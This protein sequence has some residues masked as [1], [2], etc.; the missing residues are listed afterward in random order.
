MAYVEIK[1]QNEKKYYYLTKNVR[2]GPN[3]W[4]K[5]RLF[6]GNKEPTQRD[7]S[8]CLKE[9]ESRSIA[10]YNSH[11]YLAQKD[12]EL[13]EDLRKSYSQ[14]MARMPK[15]AQRKMAEDT[16]IRYTYN[17]N[18][19]EGNRLTL[20]QTAMILKDRIM[21]HGVSSR[22]YNEAIN[23]KECLNYFRTYRGEL[24]QT[25]L[26]TVN[27]ILT[28]NTGIETSGQ[29]R[30][31]DVFIE[32]SQHVPPDHPKVEAHLLNMFKW[33]SRNKKKL[34]P[35]ELAAMVHAKIAWIHPFE[36]GNGRTARALMNFLLMRK[37]YPLLYIPNEDREI[38][39]RSLEMADNGD[40][41]G[42]ISELVSLIKDQMT[43]YTR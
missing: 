3:S 12:A 29:V 30:D 27:G 41:N 28:K 5:V 6:L 38:Y 10:R 35:F 33:Y 31:F 42:Y 2:T 8:R 15:S 4:K 7:I 36:D 23:G 17:S 34:H 19:I 13:L 14:W 40:H 22:D 32:G 20:R 16:I 11:R 37:G 24:N 43:V 1:R 18:A 26:L 21:P 25:L 9:I 39:Y